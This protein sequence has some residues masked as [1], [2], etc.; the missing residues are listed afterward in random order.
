MSG[1]VAVRNNNSAQSYKEP[2]K[3]YTLRTS[4]YTSTTEPLPRPTAPTAP[5]PPSGGGRMTRFNGRT[6][7][8]VAQ[9][10]AQHVQVP[11]GI[12]GIFGNQTVIIMAW[13][14]ALA[15]IFYAEWKEHHILARPKRLWFTSLV[16][17][18]LCVVGMVEALVPLATALAVGY[19]IVLGWQFFN[20]QGQFE[21]AIKNDGGG[22]G[23]GGGKR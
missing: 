23:G 22:S 14:I 10:A 1:T 20:E 12:P 18:I 4:Q 15:I 21:N 6:A 5:A 3:V 19:T 8:F 11:K 9:G 13:M 7:S 2:Q 16:Y 17:G